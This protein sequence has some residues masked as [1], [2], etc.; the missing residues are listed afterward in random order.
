M[1]RTKVRDLSQERMFLARLQTA[2]ELRELSQL[3]LGRRA[4]CAQSAISDWF[5][6][7]SMPTA[8]VL[9]KMPKIL[10]VSGHWLLT[11][12]GPMTP[13]IGE[14]DVQKRDSAMGALQALTT[15]ELLVAQEKAAWIKREHEA[16]WPEKA[17]KEGPW[18]AIGTPITSKPPT[19]AASV[20]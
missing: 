17:K 15:V 6:R 19:G 5:G 20:I 10:K 11:G 14:R 1:G 3:E 12:E 18:Q 7:G 9:L 4:K 13:F 8:N 16:L 2:M